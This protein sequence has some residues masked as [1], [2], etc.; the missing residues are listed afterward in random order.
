MANQYDFTPELK[1]KILDKIRA[2]HSPGR[3]QLNCPVCG[4]WDWEMA[5]GF[6]AVP[7]LWNVWT[8]NRK[9]SLPCAAL[10]CTTCSNTLFF[11]LV[12]LGFA[13]DIG[14]DMDEMRKRW[15][16]K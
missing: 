4:F 3:T 8:D 13:L 5:D 11:N 6:V 7:L 9:S 10:I 16:L 14:P 12:A 1:A 2:I 15:G